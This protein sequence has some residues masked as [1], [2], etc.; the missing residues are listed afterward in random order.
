MNYYGR[1][2]VDYY[3]GWDNNPDLIIGAMRKYDLLF[4]GDDY[5]FETR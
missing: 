3:V 4:F 2:V 5:A 1:R